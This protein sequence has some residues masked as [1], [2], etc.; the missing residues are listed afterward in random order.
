MNY[1]TR[2]E[3]NRNRERLIRHIWLHGTWAERV[4]LPLLR[5]V[6]KRE[7]RKEAVTY[8]PRR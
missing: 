5:L 1:T 6:H 4:W 3:N 2:A 8:A 7:L